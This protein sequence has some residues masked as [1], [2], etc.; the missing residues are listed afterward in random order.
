EVVG[1]ALV[2]GLS[3][4][5]VPLSFPLFRPA[6]TAAAFDTKVVARPANVEGVLA[7]LLGGGGRLDHFE[8]RVPF[9][10]SGGIEGPESLAEPFPPLVS[11]NRRRRAGRGRQA[12][13]HQHEGRYP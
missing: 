1:E 12:G 7:P 5:D 3:G 8:D 10:G 6:S 2:P 4:R 13:Q 11:G 9:S